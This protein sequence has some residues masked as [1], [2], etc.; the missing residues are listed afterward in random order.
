MKSKQFS[1]LDFYQVE[2]IF[3]YEVGLID[4]DNYVLQADLPSQNQ[5]FLKV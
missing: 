3:F 4:E 2:D 5:M 1:G